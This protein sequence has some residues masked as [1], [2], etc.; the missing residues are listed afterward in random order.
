MS[1]LF[2]GAFVTALIAASSLTIFAANV[3]SNQEMLGADL[4]DE[5]R[6]IFQTW[7]QK[8]EKVYDKAED[9]EYRFK[10]FADNHLKILKHNA[11]LDKSFTMKVCIFY[12]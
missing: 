7:M 4:H 8:F 2:L 10:V 9:I 12:L 1:K 6:E 5:I 3:E 11:Q